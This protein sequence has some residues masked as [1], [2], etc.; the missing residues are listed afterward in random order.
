MARGRARLVLLAGETGGETSS[1]LTSL[2]STPSHPAA[3]AYALSLLELRKSPG[4]DGDAPSVHEVVESAFFETVPSQLPNANVF[5]Q[6]MLLSKKITK[7]AS[8]VQF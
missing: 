4:A 2:A 6:R 3:R 5:A 8:L 7:N 1:F